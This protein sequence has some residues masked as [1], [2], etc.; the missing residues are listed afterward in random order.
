MSELKVKVKRVLFFDSGVGGLSILSDVM[1]LNKDI[2]PYYL[3]DNECFP[4][5]SKTEDFLINRIKSL[6]EQINDQFN[7]NAIVIACNTASTIALPFLRSAIKVPIVGVVPAVKPAAKISQNKII[8]LLATPGTLSRAYTKKLID[9]FASDCRLIC[10][11]DAML[12]VIAETRL[13][14]GVVDKDSIKKIVQPFLSE[15]LEERPDT[16]VLGCTHYPFVKDVLK[17]L[18]PGMNIID[19]GEAIGRRVKDV[20][21]NTPS[22]DIKESIPRA[23]YTG[24]LL[25]YEGRL[26]MVK[27][28]GFEKLEKFTVSIK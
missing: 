22:L 9:K 27:K 7:F 17:E 6:I 13:T 11:G 8:G 1:K 10:V 5:G 15:K 23:F 3:F 25:D 20:I 16:V 19:S 21:R 28:F 12:A 14:T 24:H 26:Q 4:Y 2:E 18:L